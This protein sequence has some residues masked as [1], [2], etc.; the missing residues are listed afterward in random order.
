M[1]GKHKAEY[2]FY[3]A[4]SK[5]EGDCHRYSGVDHNGLSD[6]GLESV[7]LNQNPYQKEKFTATFV[8]D[9]PADKRA[10]RMEAV[11][12][13][14]AVNGG[15]KA[16][17]NS[18]GNASGFSVTVENVSQ[19]D[20]MKLVVALTHDAPKDARGDS[21]HYAVLGT[22]VAG[23]IIAGELKRLDLSPVE[24]GLVSINT[25]GMSQESV[26]LKGTT[27]PS[28]YV[29]VKFDGYPTSPVA[30]IREVGKMA[31]LKGAVVYEVESEVELRSGQAPRVLQA[32]KDA[33]LPA[34][35]IED[36]EYVIVSA[37]VDSVTGA[38]QKA[39]LVAPAIHDAVKSAAD[40]AHPGQQQINTEIAAEC[41]ERLRRITERTQ[42]AKPPAMR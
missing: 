14:L 36:G 30:A 31:E 22:E 19:K 15:V 32:M 6:K 17:P 38:L 24:A 28:V 23:Q 37:P 9:A 34:K 18:H 12:G 39:G 21:S 29:D 16:E 8:F 26:F 3:P 2:E 10:Q 11:L 35:R 20:L 7:S 42:V 5:H 4:E 13:L 41:V 33:G 40:A 25:V 1:S 27:K